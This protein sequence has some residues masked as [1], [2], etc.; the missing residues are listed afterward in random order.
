MQE[1]IPPWAGKE[2]RGGKANFRFGQIKKEDFLEGYISRPA[3]PAPLAKPRTHCYSLLGATGGAHWRRRSGTRLR[4]AG[5]LV[6]VKQRA[7]AR[8]T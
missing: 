4:R 3:V 5:V 6:R 8:S 7:P 1:D 2:G